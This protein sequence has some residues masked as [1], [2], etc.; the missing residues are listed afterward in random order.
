MRSFLGVPVRL[1]GRAIGN[2]YLTNKRGAE[3]FSADDQDLVERF[4][5]HAA[6]AIDNA[7]LHEQV[8]RLALVDERDRIGRDLHDGVIQR[9]Y[10]VTLSLDDVPEL[11]DESPIEAR[12]RVERSIVALQSAIGDIRGFIYDLRPGL[13]T[14]AEVGQALRDLADEARRSAG[15]AVGIELDPT[16]ADLDPR[17]GAALVAVA[18]EALSN[19][20]RH[21]GATTASVTLAARDGRLRLTISDD[22]HGFDPAAPRDGRHEGLANMAERIQATGGRLV[23]ESAP[24]RGTTILA[25]VPAPAGSAGSS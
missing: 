7:R 8:T 17:L 15:I 21:A 1:R 18:R 23:I 10:A 24:G 14:P 20:G 9:L 5:L 22:G 13:S 19:V 11:M 12:D 6:V 2:F 4:A 3:E 16:L 25:D